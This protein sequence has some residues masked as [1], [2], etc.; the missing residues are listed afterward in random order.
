MTGFAVDP[1]FEAGP[2]QSAGGALGHGGEIEQGQARR[3]VPSCH[4]LQEGALPASDIH[5]VPDP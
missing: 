3:R 5:Q 4:R 2:R 1:A